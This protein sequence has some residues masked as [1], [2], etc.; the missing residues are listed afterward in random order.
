MDGSTKDGRRRGTGE[1]NYEEYTMI[2][3]GRTYTGAGEEVDGG[4]GKEGIRTYEEEKEEKKKK[5]KGQR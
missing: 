2:I 1:E 3:G 4:W 5:R